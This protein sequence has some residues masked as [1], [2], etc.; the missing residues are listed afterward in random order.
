VR[1]IL[2]K[3]EKELITIRAI[4]DVLGVV[5][6]CEL[7]KNTLA[8]LGVLISEAGQRMYEHVKQLGSASF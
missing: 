6:A 4:C 7:E 3:A 5:D 8:C 1:E 2:E